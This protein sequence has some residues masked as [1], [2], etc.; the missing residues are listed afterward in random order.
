M[1]VKQEQIATGHMRIQNQLSLE[2][3]D[4]K[5]PI[6]RKSF[7]KDPNID[8]TDIDSSTYFQL[9]CLDLFVVHT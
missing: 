9:T 2:K 6:I 3:K 8:Q 4:P 5:N 1:G 7:E